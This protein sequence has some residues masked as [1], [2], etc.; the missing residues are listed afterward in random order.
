MPSRDLR[1]NPYRVAVPYEIADGDY[2]TV[3]WTGTGT[4]TGTDQEC[5]LEVAEWTVAAEKANPS[6]SEEIASKR[7]YDSFKGATVQEILRARAGHCASP[8]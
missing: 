8:S 2:V 4:N 1:V 3:L 6:E 5:Q 7:I